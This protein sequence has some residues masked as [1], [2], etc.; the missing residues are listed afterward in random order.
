[1]D[2]QC[3]KC[4]EPWD[5]DCLHDAVAE[6]GL[7]H[8]RGDAYEREFR[9]V[10][11]EFRKL[12]CSVLGGRC[13]EGV[14][15]HPGV[16]VAYD[17]FGDDLDGAASMLEDLDRENWDNLGTLFGSITSSRGQE[18]AIF[19]FEVHSVPLD[20]APIWVRW[21]YSQSSDSGGT[22]WDWYKLRPRHKTARP[23]LREFNSVLLT[24]YDGNRIAW[25][26]DVANPEAK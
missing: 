5:M 18:M 12:G 26:V 2:I 9:K 16:A 1:M 19:P 17:V 3:V 6:R 24:Y 21:L 22:G 23:E 8:L 25:Q 11:A 13:P 4:G 14:K 7:G 10:S 15:A 20:E